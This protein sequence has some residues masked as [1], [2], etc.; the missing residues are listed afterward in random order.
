MVSNLNER[1][2]RAAFIASL[3]KSQLALA[4]ILDSIADVAYSSPHTARLLRDNVS[5]LTSMQET[6]AEAA[7]YLTW[8]R[9]MKRRGKPGKPWLHPKTRLCGES[10]TAL[11][12]WSGGEYAEE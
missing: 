3:A 2:A 4:R 7:T 9:R 1:E 5:S 12:N 8:R 6:I 11:R 10:G